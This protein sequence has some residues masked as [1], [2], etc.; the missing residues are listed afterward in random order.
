MSESIGLLLVGVGQPVTAYNRRPWGGDLH[1]IPRHAP[2][3]PVLHAQALNL[4]LRHSSGRCLGVEASSDPLMA[5]DINSAPRLISAAVRKVGV[6]LN[7]S[8][9][10]FVNLSQSVRLS[11][12]F[13][14]LEGRN[15]DDVMVKAPPG[16]PPLPTST[17]RSLRWQMNSA[18]EN[19]IAEPNWENFKLSLLPRDSVGVLECD[20]SSSGVGVGSGLGVEVSRVTRV[21]AGSGRKGLERCE[22]VRLK[23]R[24]VGV[25][26]LWFGRAVVLDG[27]STEKGDPDAIGF[28][29]V[30]LAG[31]ST[32][33]GRVGFPDRALAKDCT[34][35]LAL[36]YAPRK[37]ESQGSSATTACLLIPF[38]LGEHLGD[39][40]HGEPHL[41][42]LF[43]DVVR[44]C[45]CPES[46]HHDPDQ[47]IPSHL[48]GPMLDPH[49]RQELLEG[50]VIFLRPALET[51]SIPRLPDRLHK[52]SNLGSNGPRH[53]GPSGPGIVD[54]WP[55]KECG[56]GTGVG[57]VSLRDRGGELRH[58]RII[59]RVGLLQK[60][61]HSVWK[62]GNATQVSS[63]GR[64]ANLSTLSIPFTS[65]DRLIVST[66]YIM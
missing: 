9:N 61:V 17:T 62:G 58:Y 2:Q 10:T 36:R 21:G 29:R 31:A 45:P 1:Q 66:L 63:T 19:L 38:P 57:G 3:R 20:L 52:L 27:S 47:S 5:E 44:V 40:F 34:S 12:C 30:V 39:G 53:L 6:G 51:H 64:Q 48:V 60:C 56:G 13:H 37:A 25:V 15:W 65:L 16:V 35:G 50:A 8:R 46:F 7:L 18:N 42:Q 32:L 26:G 24:G 49:A 28:G 59:T 43:R 11:R 41:H 22:G 55:S 4:V 14:V 23:L 33:G 54:G